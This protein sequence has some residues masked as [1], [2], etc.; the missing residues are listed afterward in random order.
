MH[1]ITSNVLGNVPQRI[2]C[3]TTKSQIKRTPRAPTAPIFEN[4]YICKRQKKKKTRKFLLY[5]IKINFA[6]TPSRMTFTVWL[7][8]IF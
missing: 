7:R 5:K 3:C 4:I 2:Q 8:A 6:C 1:G